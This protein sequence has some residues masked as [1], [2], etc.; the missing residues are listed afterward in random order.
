MKGRHASLCAPVPTPSASCSPQTSPCST[1]PGPSLHQPRPWGWG[2]Q[3]RSGEAGLLPAHPAP[4]RTTSPERSIHS[5]SQR[6]GPYFTLLEGASCC[7]LPWPSQ[8]RKAMDYP[9]QRRT[10]GSL[11][12]QPGALPGPSLPPLL[13]L[14]LLPPPSILLSI[15]SQ[16]PSPSHRIPA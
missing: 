15:L 1:P 7:P 8:W 14:W 3:P 13:G 9:S 16:A 10:P 11:H 12:P 4:P 2:D 5:G 6:Q